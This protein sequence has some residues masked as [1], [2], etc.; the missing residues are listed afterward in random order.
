MM[1]GQPYFALSIEHTAK[2]APG[3]RE[4]RS[5]LDRFQIAGLEKQNAVYSNFI[6]EFKG[7]RAA[8]YARPPI[9][10]PQASFS[11]PLSHSLSLSLSHTLLSFFLFLLVYLFIVGLDEKR[12]CFATLCPFCFPSSHV[13]PA[14]SSNDAFFLSSLSLQLP[15]SLHNFL[16]PLIRWIIFILSGFRIMDYLIKRNIRL[17]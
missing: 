13:P 14:P 9:A 15:K 2:V 5:R 4:V 3:D 6:R 10:A 8:R 16:Q 7:T 11:H 12:M 17:L 1:N